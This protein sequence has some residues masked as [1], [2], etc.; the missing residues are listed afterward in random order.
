MAIVVGAGPL[1]S[2]PLCRAGLAGRSSP[3]FPRGFAG[4][5]RFSPTPRR[6]RPRWEVFFTLLANNERVDVSDLRL[7]VAVTP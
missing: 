7:Q 4:R 3:G 1:P 2:T 5:G 6:C